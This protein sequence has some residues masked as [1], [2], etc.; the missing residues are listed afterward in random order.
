MREGSSRAGAIQRARAGGTRPK[1]DGRK[2]T[3]VCVISAGV[4]LKLV[5]GGGRTS[6]GRRC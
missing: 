5:A 6:T 4:G 1:E 2:G 3:C